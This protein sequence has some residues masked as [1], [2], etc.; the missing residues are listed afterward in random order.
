YRDVRSPA[1]V[2]G[3][4]ELF[5][6]KALGRIESEIMSLA[7]LRDLEE[8]V[9]ERG[10]AVAVETHRCQVDRIAWRKA[11]DHG[12]EDRRAADHQVTATA[13][14]NDVADDI[15]AGTQHLGSAVN[16]GAQHGAAGGHDL[17]AAIGDGRADCRAAREDDL[18]AADEL[19]AT[20]HAAGG[21]DLSAA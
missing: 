17:D 7:V 21:D 6:G 14:E 2:R 20:D 5:A 15:R 11:A 1:A 8:I 19:R 9:G 16:R 12:R 18:A 13:C 3:Q 10:G 4:V